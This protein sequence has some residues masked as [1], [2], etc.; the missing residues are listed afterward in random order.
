[1]MIRCL[2]AILMLLASTI[3][4]ASAAPAS[5]DLAPDYLGTSLDDKELALSN[6]RG[7][8]VVSF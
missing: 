2:F 8:V 4:Y 7:K 6:F 5:G 3:H 1:M